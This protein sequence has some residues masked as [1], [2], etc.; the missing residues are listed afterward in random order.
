MSQL[1]S[2]A[3]SSFWVL[4]VIKRISASLIGIFFL[5]A[6]TL[7]SYASESDWMH[8]GGHEGGGRYSDLTQI[9]K[10]NVHNLEV[11]WTF[12]TGHLDRVPEKIV[13]SQTFGWIPGYPNYLAQG[14]WRPFGVMHTVQRSHC[15][16]P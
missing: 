6:G 13:V 14:C 4:G 10:D 5:A 1:I 16:R 8:Y 11:A 12:K 2:S 3:V 7:N 9:N 15:H